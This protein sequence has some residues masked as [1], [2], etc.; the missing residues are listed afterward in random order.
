M[1]LFLLDVLLEHDGDLG[2]FGA[3][4][5][6]QDRLLFATR[7]QCQIARE[8]QSLDDRLDLTAIAGGV[9][10]NAAVHVAAGLAPD[11]GDGSAWAP[12]IKDAG[13]QVEIVAVA[14]AAQ[15]QLKLASQRGL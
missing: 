15:P 14:G 8:G 2:N 5:Q 13:G 12:F 11:T 10:L 6:D 3:W 1:R 4:R 9:A 7:V